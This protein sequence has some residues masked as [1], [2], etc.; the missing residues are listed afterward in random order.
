M[1][2][3]DLL[4]EKQKIIKERLAKATAQVEVIEHQ[5]SLGRSIDSHVFRR[6]SAEF[7]NLIPK[8]KEVFGCKST[9]PLFCKCSSHLF[10]RE[11]AEKHDLYMRYFDAKEA[12]ENLVLEVEQASLDLPTFKNRA[13][14]VQK[15]KPKKTQQTAYREVQLE[16]EI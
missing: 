14:T 9:C 12:C 5:A 3:A 2:D 15:R 8:G 16:I 6:A 1:K 10:Q 13:E 4:F 7:N 11:R